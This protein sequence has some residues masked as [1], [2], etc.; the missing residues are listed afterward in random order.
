MPPA[1]LAGILASL[2]AAGAALSIIYYSLRLQSPPLPMSRTLRKSL[3]EICRRYSPARIIDC[4]SAWGNT[5]IAVAR[6]CRVPAVGIEP[7][8]VPRWFSRIFA[9]RL[10]DVTIEKGTIADIRCAPGDCILLYLGP[11]CMAAHKELVT[12]WIQA[13]AT[14]IS[15]TFALRGVPAHNIF[16]GKDIYRSPIFVYRKAEEE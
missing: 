7:S 2:F 16:Y 15:T 8:P 9:R 13:G 10:P 1:A 14:V 4:G 11:E 5:L 6:H 12:A 3:A